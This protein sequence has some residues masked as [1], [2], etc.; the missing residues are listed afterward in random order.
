MAGGMAD[1]AYWATPEGQAKMRAGGATAS[2]LASAMQAGQADTTG[3]TTFTPSAQQLGAQSAGMAGDAAS[4]AYWQT[5]QGQAQ[6]AMGQAQT[7]TMAPPPAGAPQPA[8]YLED[9]WKQQGGGYFGPSNMDQAL[10]GLRDQLSGPGQAEQFYTQAQNT[11]TDPYYQ[12][13]QKQ[14]EDSLNQQMAVRGHFNSGAAIAGLGNFDA[15]LKAQQ[16][17]DMGGLANAAQTQGQA[18]AGLLGQVA[19]ATDTIDANRMNSGFNV[20]GQAQGQ[21]MDRVNSFL[22]QQM[23]LDSS[24]AKV[25]SDAYAKGGDISSEAGRAAI[26]AQVKSALASAGGTQAQQDTAMKALTALFAAL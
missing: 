1:A 5:P 8:N 19:G 13:L 14:G 6:T 25:I 11:Q 24:T 9:L 17:H 3:S 22:G 26:E 4:T 12:R 2:Q 18:R 16:Y 21:N 23:G 7:N 20:A 15:G 10:P